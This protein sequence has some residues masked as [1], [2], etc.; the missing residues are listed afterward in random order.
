[1]STKTKATQLGDYVCKVGKYDI[2]HT[3]IQPIKE[4][5]FTGEIIKTKGSVIA[6]TYLG[7]NLVKGGFNDH[8]KAI[9]YAWNRLK[10]SGESH[11]VKK[12]L[13]EKYN[14]S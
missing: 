11:H 14:L 8:S 13:V 4:K 7:K 6:G 10:K 1:M 5:S 2:R 12:Q 9:Q 3:V